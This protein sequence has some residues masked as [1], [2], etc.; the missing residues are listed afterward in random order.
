MRPRNI[1]HEEQFNKRFMFHSAQPPAAA[2]E[3]P[4]VISTMPPVPS[5]IPGSTRWAGNDLGQ[6]TE[7]VL[8]EE[9]GL[10]PGPV[11]ACSRRPLIQGGH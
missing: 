11:S 9:L 8:R 7:E 3:D 6:H 5:G 1:C 2:A 10:G 4:I